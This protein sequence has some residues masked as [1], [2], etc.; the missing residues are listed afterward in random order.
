MTEPAR[1]GGGGRRPAGTGL[2]LARGMPTYLLDGAGKRAVRP[3]GHPRRRKRRAGRPPPR[4]WVSGPSVHVS[5][6]FE[7][8]LMS[9]LSLF[10]SPLVL[11][12][13]HFE[14]VLDRVSR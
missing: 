9:R 6:S 4:P 14:R 7:E 10:N 8:S 12:F 5:R 11:G 2:V 13:D 1:G 3:P